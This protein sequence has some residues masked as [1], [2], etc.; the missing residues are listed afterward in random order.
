[1]KYYEILNKI[2]SMTDNGNNSSEICK[3]LNITRYKFY[4]T[5]ICAGI[6]Y[7]KTTGGITIDA[8]DKQ[9]RTR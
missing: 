8:T 5:C 6:K 1:M 3:S 4:N 7:N 2:K 9:K